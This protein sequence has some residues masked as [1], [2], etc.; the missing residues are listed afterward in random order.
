[1]S[2]KKHFPQI[3]RFKRFENGLE[4][5]FPDLK[6]FSLILAE[7]PLFFPDFPDWKKSSKFSLNSLISLIGGNPG[8]LFLEDTFFMLYKVSYLLQLRP[9][10]NW[11]QQKSI[12]TVFKQGKSKSTEHCY[13]CTD[14]RTVAAIPKCLSLKILSIMETVLP[15]KGVL[16]LQRR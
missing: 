7:K 1:M 6:F 12:Q 8:F 13:F 15:A 9:S 16:H 4:K 2:L 14:M 11:I 5:K 10:V 3:Y